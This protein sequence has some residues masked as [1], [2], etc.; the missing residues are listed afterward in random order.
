MLS[1]PSAAPFVCAS[2]SLGYR[3]D[4]RVVGT[5]GN[6]G[7]VVAARNDSTSTAIAMHIKI[8]QST[9]WSVP[10]YRDSNK[11]TLASVVVKGSS[12]GALERP[13]NVGT[14]RRQ[15]SASVARA[16]REDLQRQIAH[17]DPARYE[18]SVPR[19]ALL[20]A[21]T[22]TIDVKH[23]LVVKLKI[24]SAYCPSYLSTALEVQ[25]SPLSAGGA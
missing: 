4:S 8:K 23:F 9:T 12:L 14:A 22:D 7:L 6:V 15:S 10:G 25:R 3:V 13:A 19:N 11:Q 17:G 24:K 16:A 18:L 21:K 1:S 20:T 2:V 5:A